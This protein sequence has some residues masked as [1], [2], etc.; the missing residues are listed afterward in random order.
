MNGLRFDPRAVIR[1]AY[2]V[3][4]AIVIFPRMLPIKAPKYP[5]FST[6]PSKNCIISF[7]VTE[8]HIHQITF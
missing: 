8:H 2:G 3:G 4:K 1:K 5:Y 6:R 7:K